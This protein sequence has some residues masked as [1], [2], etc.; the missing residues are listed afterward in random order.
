MELTKQVTSREISEKMCKLGFRQESF[1]WWE[2]EETPSNPNMQRHEVS[3]EFMPF[4]LKYGCQPSKL[5]CSHT[6]KEYSAYS[7]SEL[8]EML[9][10]NF[11]TLKTDGEWF[12][13]ANDFCE[14]APYDDYE[15][16]HEE[17]ADTEA[18]AR[19]LML[20]YLAENG[21]IQITK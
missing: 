4:E 17:S 2:Q 11:N 20:I 3:Q 12:C 15:I 6:F 14:V 7:C 8:G 18:D 13:L 5:N 1:L 16:P 9:P 19:G 21:L 10:E